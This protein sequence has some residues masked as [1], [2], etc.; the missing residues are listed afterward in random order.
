[1]TLGSTMGQLIA[2]TWVRN[3]RRKTVELERLFLAVAKHY[4]AS[5]ESTI[6]FFRIENARWYD[7]VAR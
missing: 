6:A 4:D 2:E 3:R 1:M 7:F 5:L